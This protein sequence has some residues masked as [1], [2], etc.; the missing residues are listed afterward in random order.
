M[1]RQTCT[2]LQ[3]ESAGDD[4]EAADANMPDL[5]SLFD[6]PEEDA[7]SAA[8][9]QSGEDQFLHGHA[10]ADTFHV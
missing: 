2:L 3:Q 7:E 4:G 9:V 6:V 8:K 5:G 10:A 1:S